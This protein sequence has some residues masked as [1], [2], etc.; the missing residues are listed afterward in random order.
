MKDIVIVGGGLA[1]LTAARRAAELGLTGSVLEKG[2][3]A[4]Y[5]CN[6]RLSGG[7]LAVAGGNP[8]SDA[9]TLI[10][11]INT[12]THGDTDPE[13]AKLLAENAS[14]SIDWLVAQGASL[15]RL[16][17]NE[18]GQW[19]ENVLAPIGLKKGWVEWEDKGPDRLLHSLRRSVEDAGWSCHLG[20]AVGRLLVEQGTIVGVEAMTG[21]GPVEHRARAVVL[22]DGGFQ[23][24][25]S[26]VK[27]FI[28]PHPEELVQRGSGTGS[29]VGLMLAES[30]G[31]RLVKTDSFYGHLLSRD[32]LTNDHLWP[33]P[34]L[35]GPATAGI[36]V[37]R[38]GCRFTDEGRGAIDV[39]NKL[40]RSEDPGGAWAV[41]DDAIWAD[42]AGFTHPPQPNPWLLEHGGSI[43]SAETIS[44]LAERTGLPE[45][46]AT[47]NGYNDAV[48]A[49]VTPS[50]PVPRSVPSRALL[51]AS[52]QLRPIAKPPF[53]AL[54]VRPGVTFTMGGPLID[55]NAQ[56]VHEAGEPIA[57][58][59]AVGSSSAGFDGGEDVGYVGG[60][61][62]SLVTGLVAAEHI[63]ETV[64][65][66]ERAAG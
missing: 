65:E 10:D 53:H 26:L 31:A 27:R 38:R 48:L 40:A 55:G 41:I 16:E 21:S 24:N 4:S 8:R 62:K 15:Q 12:A 33:Y 32:A 45:L 49:G 50:L 6:T 63:S 37:D 1:G 66:R 2:S 57:G 42:A 23:S 36:V 29:G 52:T 28:S 46:E 7:V 9:A 22:A 58:L 19:H 61:V 59:Y 30:V 5:L 3:S 64:R 13:L 17:L 34:I 47:V 39:A 11:L 35:D 56:V 54:P 18:P 14:R 60:L 51:F 44:G 20:H 43:E 25:P